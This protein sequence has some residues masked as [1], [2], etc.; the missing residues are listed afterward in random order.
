V[1][2]TAPGG[3]I[4]VTVPYGRR[5]DHGRLRQ[6]D[7]QDI[8]KLL[9]GL[10]GD[11]SVA[12]FDYSESGWQ[13]SNLDGAAEKRYRDFLADPSPVPDRAAAARAVVCVSVAL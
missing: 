4:L 8:E 7:P 5:E 3:H 12:V 9:A 6:F 2:V 13:V 11:P 1:R 10:G